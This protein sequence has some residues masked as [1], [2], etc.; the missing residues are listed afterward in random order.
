MRETIAE[1]LK[2]CGFAVDPVDRGEE[3]LAAVAVATYDGVILDLGLPDMDGMDVLRELRNARG[4]QMPALILSARDGIADRVGGLDAGADDYILKPFALTEL[5]ARLRAVL[6][7]PGTRRD[8]TYHFGDLSFDPASRFAAVADTA[9]ELARREASVLEELIRAGGRIVV[10]DVL[11]ER[12][13]GFD[14]DVGSNAL[15]F[16]I[17]AAAQAS[18]RLLQDRDRG[19][20]GYRLSPAT[21]AWTLRR[22]LG[23]LRGRLLAGMLMVFLLG[24][25]GALGLDPLDRQAQAI[26]GRHVFLFQDPYQDMLILLVYSA[27]AILLIWLVSG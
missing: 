1:H 18:V 7:R 4:T 9:L 5:E 2:A 8:T 14:E 3:A 27:C 15:D 17:E 20:A 10:K 24:L 22:A 6:R 26:A 21:R 11:E 16:G 19:G 12:V 25:G 13:Y 23:S